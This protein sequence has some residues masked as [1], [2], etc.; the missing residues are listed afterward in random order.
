M[1]LSQL[2]NLERTAAALA[3]AQPVPSAGPEPVGDAVFV[4]SGDSLAACLLA[5]RF[6]YRAVSAGD[7]AWSTVM[8]RHCDTIVGVSY[9][10]GT[11]ATVRA[12]RAAHRAGFKTAAV[13]SNPESPLALAADHIFPVPTAAAG[14]ALPAAGYISLATGV[15][16]ACGVATTDLIPRVVNALDDTAAQ[17]HLAVGSLPS[18]PPAAISIL[19]LPDLR[20]A[21]DFWSL[22]LIEATG[23]AVRALALEESGHVDYFIGPQSHLVIDLIG[24]DSPD[25]HTR[26][27]QALAANGQHVISIETELP[28]AA[29][30]DHGAAQVAELATAAAGAEFARQ[31]AQ[32]WRR[33]P[34]RGGEVAMEGTH[35]R[36]DDTKA[37]TP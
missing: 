35:I 14:E 11:G 15:L 1:P 8:P 4:G 26:L 9:S 19:S 37:G 10:G 3:E 22:K 36:L 29:V 16:N 27:T 13:T 25:R 23:V 34:F 32:R 18:Q 30:D 21:A 12:L 31:A 6:G 33:L 28:C 17:I 24:R 20:S 7:L 2:A 5:E